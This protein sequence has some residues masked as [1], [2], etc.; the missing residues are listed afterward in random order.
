M[1]VLDKGKHAAC[2]VLK[3]SLSLPA[4]HGGHGK[5]SL[6]RQPVMKMQPR[7]AVLAALFPLVVAGCSASTAATPPAAVPAAPAA[8][9]V[10]GPGF[11]CTQLAK[12][13]G[14]AVVNISVTKEVATQM[15]QLDP[16]DPFYQFFRRFQAPVPRQAPERGIGSGFIISP[17][18]YILT[19]AHVVD[20]VKE[21]HVK[22]TDRREF[23]AKLA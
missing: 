23:T 22:L 6:W 10:R 7:A 3:P 17:D 14:P 9:A 8:P 16:N 11:D 20:G 19:N 1:D 15:P 2:R 13:E 18:G 4:Q 12:D 5:T 21:V